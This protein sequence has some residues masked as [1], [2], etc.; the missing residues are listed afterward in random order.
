[1]EMESDNSKNLETVRRLVETYY[2]GLLPTVRACLSVCC[3]M[4]FAN[5]TRPLSLIL[6]TTSGH[7]KSAVVQMFF[8]LEQ[9]GGLSDHIYRCDKFTPKAFVT[10]ATNVPREK[11][12]EIAC[13]HR[14]RT[15]CS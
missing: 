3:S 15:R 5:R 2:S 11:L 6:E 7:G 10:H 12:A 14:S 4:A 13:C 1:M 8:P 9:E